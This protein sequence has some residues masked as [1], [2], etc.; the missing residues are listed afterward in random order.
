[1]PF[2]TCDGLNLNYYLNYFYFHYYVIL[3]YFVKL[4]FS[5][6]FKQLY[7]MKLYRLNVKYL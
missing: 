6:W 1:M 3:N 7:R 5:Q 2:S 4:L